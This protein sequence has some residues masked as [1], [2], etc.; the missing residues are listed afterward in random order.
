MYP[1]ELETKI[2]NWRAKQLAG[3]MT[4]EDWREALAALRAGRVSALTSSESAKRKSAP[5]VIDAHAMLDELD[6]I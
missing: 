3:E 4:K 5:K 2:A 6:G 1:P